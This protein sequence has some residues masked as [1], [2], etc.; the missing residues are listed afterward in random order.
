[1]SGRDNSTTCPG[2]SDAIP[3]PCFHMSDA[4]TSQIATCLHSAHK[5]SQHLFSHHSIAP[6]QHCRTAHP[7]LMLSPPQA[8]D[9]LRTGCISI[10]SLLVHILQSAMQAKQVL[11]M[12]QRIML[13]AIPDSDVGG[14]ESMS[15]PS[16]T[17]LHH[18]PLPEIRPIVPCRGN[19]LVEHRLPTFQYCPGVKCTY[20]LR[21]MCA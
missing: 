19:P 21:E 20:D 1:M 6:G 5:D 18:Q 15:H 13:D 8:Y 11:C 12:H 10:E 17:P 3:T 14:R 7:T 16:G 4:S 2:L 9:A